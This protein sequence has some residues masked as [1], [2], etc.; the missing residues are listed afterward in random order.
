MKTF[1]QKTAWGTTVDG[2]FLTNLQT[3]Q[4]CRTEDGYPEP[5]CTAAIKIPGLLIGEV[6]I[7]DYSENE[8]ILDVL[9]SAGI[10]KAPHRYIW[11]DRVRFPV[12]ILNKDVARE[13][14]WREPV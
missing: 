3:L 5:W 10:V 7:K 4:I 14:L 6:A 12:C 9:V 1:S 8:G 11:Q 13:Y 2:L